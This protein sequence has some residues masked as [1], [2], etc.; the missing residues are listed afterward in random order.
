[1]GLNW[2]SNLVKIALSTN[3][4]VVFDEDPIKTS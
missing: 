1:M 3:I 2:V 4:T